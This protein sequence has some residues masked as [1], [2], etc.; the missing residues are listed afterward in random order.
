MQVRAGIVVSMRFI[1][2]GNSSEELPPTLFD[3]LSGAN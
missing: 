2:T 1:A 3:S